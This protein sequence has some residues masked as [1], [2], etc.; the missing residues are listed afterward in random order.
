MAAIRQHVAARWRS[1]LSTLF[2]FAAVLLAVVGFVM[3]SWSN[4]SDRVYNVDVGTMAIS[5]SG[6]VL[7]FLSIPGRSRGRCAPPWLPR[8]P[9][10]LMACDEQASA[11]FS[12]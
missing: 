7:L 10:P 3:A 4:D 11:T 6:H 12:A 8:T 2:E 9:L 5:L 1:L